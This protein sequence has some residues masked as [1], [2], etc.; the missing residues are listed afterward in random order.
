V[1]ADAGSLPED[2]FKVTRLHTGPLTV[3]PL[4]LLVGRMASAE[5]GAAVGAVTFA[6]ATAL[7][8]ALGQIPILIFR[9][10]RF[11]THA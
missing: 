6:P 3:S 11:S 2:N 5:H 9:S 7:R 1:K 4:F 10:Y 8:E